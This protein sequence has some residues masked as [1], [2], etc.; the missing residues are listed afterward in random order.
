MYLCLFILCYVLPYYAQPQAKV[1]SLPLVINTWPFT[2]ATKKGWEVIYTNKG[3]NLDAVVAGCT[4]CEQQQCDGSVGF[5]GSPD[6]TGET[7]LDAM[8]MDG[9]THDVGAVGD[10]RRVKNAIGVARAVMDHTENTLIVG[11]S[12]TRF[13]IE[14]G[15]KEESLATNSS[16]AEWKKWKMSNCQPNY[17]KNVVPDPKTHCGPY[18]PEH[19]QL[20]RDRDFK[21]PVSRLNH[22]TIGIIVI[23]DKGRVAAGTSTNGLTFKIHGRVGDS[24]IMGAGSYASNEA[25]AAAATGDGDIMMRFLPSFNAVTMLANGMS[26]DEAAK[27]SIQPIIR[28]YPKFVGAVIVANVSGDYGAACHGLKSFHFSVRVKEMSD[29]TVVEVPCI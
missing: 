23:D 18:T 10:L 26:V 8:I 7:T 27:R 29:V 15:F 17:W 22:D 9:D 11:E 3:S 24:P 1:L 2:N 6:E 14:M 19:S 12:A 28:Y 21:K 4:E 5:G 13:A 20:L 16:L 25:G